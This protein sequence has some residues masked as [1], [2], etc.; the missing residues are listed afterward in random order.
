MEPDRLQHHPAVFFRHLRLTVLLFPHKKIVARFKTDTFSFITPPPYHVTL[1]CEKSGK[2][3]YPSTLKS[4]TLLLEPVARIA[5]VQHPGSVR[6]KIVRCARYLGQL[7]HV[8]FGTRS[9]YHN[10]YIAF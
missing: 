7:F 6:F 4:K 1:N 2:G 8:A 10:G 3:M 5:Y 9:F